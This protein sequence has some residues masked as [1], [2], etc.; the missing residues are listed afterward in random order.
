MVRKIVKY[1]FL[2]VSL[3]VACVL[4][5]CRLIPS[6]NP[7]EFRFVGILTYLVPI[8]TLFN[9]FFIV[10][11]FLTKKYY[12]ILIPV[13]A[14]MCC[15]NIIS[16]MFG[17]HIW[18]SKKA[19]TPDHHFSVMSYNVRLLD[20]YHWSGEKDTRKKMIDFIKQTQADVL[21]LQEFYSGGSQKGVNNI[22]DIQTQCGYPYYADCV[23]NSNKRGI[24][25]SII[26]SRLP[27][28]WHKNH[29]IDVEGSN[30]LQ[31]VC[32]THKKDTFT[33]YNIHLK[34]NKFTS[35]ESD[36]VGSKEVPVWNQSTK[37]VTKA[38]YNK[39]EKSSMNRGLE[40]DLVSAKVSKSKYP[41]IVCGDLN[42]IPGSY[43]YFKMRNSMKDLFLSEGFG[44]GAT[45]NKGIPLLRIDYIFYDPQL[46]V[47]DYKKFNTH[48]S[49]HYPI[50]GTFSLSDSKYAQP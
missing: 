6:L 3:A 25:G 1:G 40:A 15:W 32:L 2:L 34:S 49:D 43:T 12:F 14:I 31:E 37:A 22:K 28:V 7:F 23:M 33:V 46:S 19:E 4:A 13:L 39:L 10:F 42:D 48:F 38:I 44:L 50:L 29:D 9:L 36:L 41:A 8:F 16:V 30:L 18:R 11:W 26:F 35:D 45:Y 5:F 20:L 17:G 47:M 21:C 24:W 27:I